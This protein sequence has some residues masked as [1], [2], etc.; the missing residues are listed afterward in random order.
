MPGSARGRAPVATMICLA[1]VG[2]LA[3]CVLRDRTLRLDDCLGGL[4]N[5]DLVCLSE[6]CLAPDHIDLVLLHQEGNA[7]VHAL[8]DAART[9]DDGLQVR[10][11]LAFERQAVI[12]GMFG[13][14]QHFGR[15]QQRLGRNAAPVGA[16]ACQMLAFDNGCLEAKLGGP[17][18]R[19]IAA[20][21]G[22][23]DDHV[24]I[25]GHSRFLPLP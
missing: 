15:A 12:L 13:K 16:D 24:V 10:R 1:V 19:D 7:A 8:G 2:A 17:D 25:I 9:L 23:D 18:G 6:L 3:Q 11:N 20:G 21:A 5:N 4:G 14:M 22:T